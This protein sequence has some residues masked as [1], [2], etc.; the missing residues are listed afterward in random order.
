MIVGTSHNLMEALKERYPKAQIDELKPVIK[1]TNSFNS[2]VP[3]AATLYFGY[4]NK[5]TTVLIFDDIKRDYQP[6][7][8]EPRDT[9]LFATLPQNIPDET[10]QFVG[11]EITSRVPIIPA[12]VFHAVNGFF[13]DDTDNPITGTSYEIKVERFNP[14]DDVNTVAP[15]E[16]NVIAT[17]ATTG[18][19][20]AGFLR[21]GFKYRLLSNDEAIW[22]LHFNPGAFPVHWVN[23]TSE[24]ANLDQAYVG[25]FLRALTL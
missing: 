23:N 3:D 6:L 13:T 8:V 15:I 11:F 22:V 5:Q 10:A 14:E 18:A 24:A 4:F 2:I 19:W 12:L 25:I 9:V 16:T 1:D 20:D 17:D 7:T 21:A